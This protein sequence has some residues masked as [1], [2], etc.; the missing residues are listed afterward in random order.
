MSDPKFETWAD[1]EAW[2]INTARCAKGHKPSELAAI[3]R[4]LR[5]TLANMHLKG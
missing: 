2:V 5:V 3:E 4:I 1:L